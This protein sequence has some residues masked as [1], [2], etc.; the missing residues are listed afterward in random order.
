MIEYIEYLWVL[1]CYSVQN[2]QFLYVYLCVGFKEMQ[3]TFQHTVLWQK[4]KVLI[5][6]VWFSQKPQNKQCDFFHP[7]C[8][9]N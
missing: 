9:N 8:P 3:Q 5:R 1:D 2:K 4:S 6:T 7:D